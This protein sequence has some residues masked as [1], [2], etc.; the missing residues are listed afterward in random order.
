MIVRVALFFAAVVV[1]APRAATVVRVHELRHV[2]AQALGRYGLGNNFLRRRDG[3]CA[4]WCRRVGHGGDGGAAVFQ[5]E[6][7]HEPEEPQSHLA[8][9]LVQSQ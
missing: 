6:R 1:W 7:V 5:E 4:R 9:V 3:V 8:T 2:I